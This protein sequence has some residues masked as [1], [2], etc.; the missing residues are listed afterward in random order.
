MKGILPFHAW[1]NKFHA[2]FR[3]KYNI[4]DKNNWYKLPTEQQLFYIQ[5]ECKITNIKCPKGS[6]VFWDSRT[7]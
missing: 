7:C 5:K 6:M 2:E 4:T 3:D 1:N